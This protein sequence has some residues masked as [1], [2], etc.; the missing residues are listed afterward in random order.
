MLK[1]RFQNSF[2]AKG[3]K[4]DLNK[5]KWLNARLNSAGRPLFGF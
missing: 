3:F 4:K 1:P 5:V 2:Q